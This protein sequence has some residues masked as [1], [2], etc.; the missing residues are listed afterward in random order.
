MSSTA[1]LQSAWFFPLI[2]FF[3]LLLLNPAQSESSVVASYAASV[4][5]RALCLR[6]GSQ[7]M[8]SVAEVGGWA[9]DL[10]TNLFA[11]LTRNPEN[12]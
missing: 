8:F 12:E 9:S 5:E 7:P 6:V 11:A 2:L 10:L 4:L 3:L 1:F